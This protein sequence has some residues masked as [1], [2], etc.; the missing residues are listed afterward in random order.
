MKISEIK[1]VEKRPI[2]TYPTSYKQLTYAHNEGYNSAL[3]IELEVNVEAMAKI[4]YKC[5]YDLDWRRCSDKT[6]YIMKAQSLSTHLK[7]ILRVK[8]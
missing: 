3:D 1:G 8:E 5:D 2:D 4:I 6:K 7:D